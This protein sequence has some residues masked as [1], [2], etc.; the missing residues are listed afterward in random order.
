ML[1]SVQQVDTSQIP[2]LPERINAAMPSIEE[3]INASASA[4][5]VSLVWDLSDRGTPPDRI[6]E[7]EL[8]DDI[9]G[10]GVEYLS[11][12]NFDRDIKVLRRRVRKLH[13]EILDRF[14]KRQAEKMKRNLSEVGEA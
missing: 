4:D 9:A 6:I 1:K 3:E 12:M 2:G 8:K 13:S 14:L 7:L 10:S 11:A 5:R